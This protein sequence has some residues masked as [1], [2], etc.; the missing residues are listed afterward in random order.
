MHQEEVE[1]VSQEA[2][3]LV[4]MQERKEQVNNRKI[5]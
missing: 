2:V 5:F 4:P 1:T 3:V